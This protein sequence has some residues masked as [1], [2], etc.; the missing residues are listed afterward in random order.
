MYYYCHLLNLLLS[1]R[2]KG[3]VKGVKICEVVPKISNSVKRVRPILLQKLKKFA[4]LTNNG[5]ACEGL[6]TSIKLLTLQK[7]KV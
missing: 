5:I 3:P 1:T 6:I 2:I 7:D 4:I